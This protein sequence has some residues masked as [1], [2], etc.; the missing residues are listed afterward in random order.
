MATLAERRVERARRVSAEH[1]FYS[2]MA[3]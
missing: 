2:G 1:W 3:A